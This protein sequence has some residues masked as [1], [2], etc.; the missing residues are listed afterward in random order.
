M[1]ES[2]FN[3][4]A[5]L[6]ACNFLKTDSNTG[7]FLSNFQNTYLE[8]HLRTIASK[9][10]DS[11]LEVLCRSNCS[12]LINALMKYSFSAALVQSWRV[13]YGNL[14]KIALHHSYFSKNLTS[15]A[16]QWYWK[17]YLDG[18]FWR[19]FYLRN[20]PVW[21]LLKSSC[22]LYLFQKFL[23]IFY[24]TYVDVILKRNGFSWFFI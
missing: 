24:I 19:R 21:L 16:E 17:I 1:L 18:W 22:R 2:L 23:H 15:V 7:V 4:V 9:H 6:K 14:L 13:P 12:A 8:G 11:F 20:I 10:R 5:G 3:K